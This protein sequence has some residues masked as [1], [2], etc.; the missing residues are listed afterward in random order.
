MA[1]FAFNV[2]AQGRLFIAE[3]VKLIAVNKIVMTDVP[4][5]VNNYQAFIL[6]VI[7]TIGYVA[8]DFMDVTEQEPPEPTWEERNADRLARMETATTDELI[9]LLKEDENDPFPGFE[10]ERS[11]ETPVDEVKLYGGIIVVILSYSYFKTFQRFKEVVDALG[12]QLAVVEV[13]K[14]MWNTSLHCTTH[15][16]RSFY[17]YYFGGAKHSRAYYE[18]WIDTMAMPDIT[19]AEQYIAAIDHLDR[20]LALPGD[21]EGSWKLTARLSDEWFTSETPDILKTLDALYALRDRRR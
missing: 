18:L 7:L 11:R 3:A 1:P 17:L 5:Y 2:F 15:D 6:I 12:P 21:N 13:V 19:G 9:E 8:V 14:F 16:G 20:I 10:E 4:W